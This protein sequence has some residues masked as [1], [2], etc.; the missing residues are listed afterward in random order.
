MLGI[1]TGLFVQFYFFENSS[2]YLFFVTDICNS[3]GIIFIGM[4]KL[5]VIPLVFISIV[6]AICNLDDV[7]QC[8]RL[9]FK[10]IFIYLINT[11]FAIISTIFIATLVGIGKTS[12][13]LM[14]RSTIL[15]TLPS[16]M[17]THK[18][19]S[20]IDFINSIVPH[21][22][23]QAF[24]DGNI[25][26]I[27]FMAIFVG[28]A[29]NKLENEQTQVVSK[30]FSIANNVIMKLTVMVMKFA[31]YGVFCLTTKLVSTLHKESLCS[32]LSYIATALLI[33]SFWIF[34]IY[35][36]ILYSLLRIKPLTFLTNVREQ[37]LFAL[38]T[39]SSNATIPISYRTLTQKMGVSER[40]AGFTI[41]LGATINMSG[42]AI[43]IT[44]SAL[45]I[46]NLYGIALSL[47][48]LFNLGVTALFM[49]VATGG[50][51]GGVIVTMG[52]LLEM[53]GLPTEAIAFIVATDRILDVGCTVSNVVGDTVVGM[54]IAH[55][56]GEKP[57]ECIQQL[58][59]VED[60]MPND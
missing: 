18:A 49:S 14:D 52:I 3:G 54:L 12:N 2:F 41:P 21:N 16:Q 32:L 17:P 39:S 53:L 40:I 30:A 51:P 36:L 38:S 55:T 58:K 7:S 46:T 45:F 29:I 23:F 50:V 1:I 24:V 37:I 5:L 56:E 31:P 20:M 47:T 4:I 26:Q 34:I 33:M 42:A 22:P 15:D 48:G 27:L 25:L 11:I 35:P 6:H 10:T 19:I 13:I 8:G 28:I 43:Y 59:S 44:V 60:I 57:S 9:G